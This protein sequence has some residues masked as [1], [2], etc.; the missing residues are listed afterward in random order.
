MAIFGRPYARQRM[1]WMAVWLIV[2]TLTLGAPIMPANGQDTVTGAFEGTVRNAL[3]DE[4]IPGASVEFINQASNVSVAK[5]ADS[6][7]RFYQGLLLPGTYT[8]RAT[9][10][11]FITN[12]TVMRLLGL[13]TGEVVPVPIAL[14][15]SAS[16]VTSGSTTNPVAPLP[17]PMSSPATAATSGAA[18]SAR[19]SENTDVRG[20]INTLDAQRGGAFTDAEIG[21]LP[22]G[23]TT[24]T[25]TFDELAL[26]VAG[27]ALP[28]QPIGAAN[29]SV[30]PGIGAGIGT[31][32]QFAVNGLRSR[33]NNFTVDGSDNNDEDIGVRRQGFVALVPQPIES[34]KEFQIITLL[35]PAQ[36]GRNIGAQVNAISKS[37]GSLTHGT[38]YGFFNASQLN[39]R[40]FFDT[41]NGNA[42]APVLTA[43]KQPVLVASSATFNSGTRNFDLVNGQALTT[44]N[45]SGGQDSFTLAHGGGVLGGA[46]ASNRLFYF[47]SAE[48]QIINATKEESFRVPTVEQRGAFNA[49]ASG[50]FNDPFNPQRS[51]FAFPASPGGDA[52]L[53]LFPFPNNPTGSYGANTFTQVL[54]ASGRGGILSGKIDHNFKFHERN[55]SFTARYNFTEDSRSIPSVGGALFST[56]RPHVR[57]QNLSLFLNSELSAPD[58]TRL[59]FNQVRLSYGRTRL[60]FDAQ[61]DTNFQIKSKLFPSDPFLLNAPLR[62]NL[63]LPN[64]T[65]GGQVVPNAGPVLLLNTGATTEDM[66]GPVGEINIGGFSRLGVDV[67]N[68]PQRRVNNTYQLADQLTIRRG[69]HSIIFGTDN[70]R[71]ELNS[72]LPRNFRPLISFYGAPTLARDPAGN[73]VITSN[74]NDP[75][76]LVGAGA[77]S[78]FFQTL[79]TG[80]DAAINLRF[81]QLDFFVQDER[82]VRPNLSFSFGLR[83]EYNTPAGET[84]RRI[85]NSFND[86][87]ISLVPGL[88]KF[89]AGRSS[90]Y[91][92]ARTNFAP[93]IGLAYAPKIFSAA[94]FTVLRAGYG[95]YYDQ[96]LGAVVS[97]SRNVFPRFLTVNLAGGLGN[98]GFPNTPLG[99]LNPAQIPT[100]VRPGTL[101]ML[102]PAFT[103]AQ[104]VALVNALASAGTTLPSASGVEFTLPSRKLRMPTAH[105][106]SVSVE[107]QL[108]RTTAISLA[109]VGTLG[110]HLLRFTTP[111]LGTSAVALLQSFNAGTDGPNR[112]VPQF[113]GIAVAPGTRLSSSGA[114]SGGR[115]V[116]TVGGLQ[117]FETSGNSRYD[118]LQVTLHGRLRRKLQYQA[119]YT[120]GKAIDDVS[121]V[122]DLAGAP[123]LPENSLTRA[124]ERAVANFDARHRLAYEAI[125][126]LP[127]VGNKGTLLRAVFNNLQ[128]A[129]TGQF[130][131]GQP[132]TVN[133]YI[134][135]NLDGNITDRLNSTQGL[136]VTGNGRQPLLLTVDRDTLRAPAG[137][138]G[139]VGRNTFRAGST[140]ELNLAVTKTFA[141]HEQH[142]LSLRVEVFNFTNRANFGIPTRILEFSNFGQTT[143][144][145]TPARRVQLG[146]RYSF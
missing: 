11:N 38:L 72:D 110:R 103:L 50:I 33:A 37:G 88:N 21:G 107:Q 34:I 74:F 63:T 106:Y 99:L 51:A 108:G 121:D 68:F 40:D 109:Y 98:P 144:T 22:L 20:Q 30:G 60:N 119:S 54:P 146:L 4:P 16:A 39:A 145:T 93:R 12:E 134:D 78:G 97:Q 79:T 24:L 10:P 59:I 27:V 18:A 19:T 6:R 56:L 46:L 14:E 2:T 17:S 104:Q 43:A 13:R 142:A 141:F 132:F 66:L 1:S 48:G 70:R 137:T 82:R 111:N 91:D 32:G 136:V 143:T 115:P 52:I 31:S 126:D 118:A 49:G 92:P 8:I 94:H 55:Q 105:Q 129:T 41:A 69:A 77:P 120:F 73:F 64:I 123:A 113:F 89:L 102:N 95:L 9:A 101:N 86:P 131:T 81:Y 127:D 125:Y 84:H 42:V 75:I 140:L 122:F 124:G 112:F 15:P 29:G 25:R 62:S 61:R 139:Q 96:I 35:A 3:T 7:G 5:R 114:F 80:L 116:P 100:L 36:F 45:E 58:A 117:I 85:E 23:S 90:I 28:P 47:L 135:V 130:Q 44:R 53:S 128:F 26:F 71:T 133:T 138:D 76:D 67:F 83:Y 57:T 65:A 87:A